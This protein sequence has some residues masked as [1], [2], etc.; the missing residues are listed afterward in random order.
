[1]QKESRQAVDPDNHQSRKGWERISSKVL[2]MYNFLYPTYTGEPVKVII[3]QD[4]GSD[5][6]V[7]LLYAFMSKKFDVKGINV[8]AGNTGVN[9]VLRNTYKALDMAGIGP[10]KAKEI[11]IHL[12]ER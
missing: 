9:N 12:P 4:G 3:D 1:M 11:G 7:A 10:D 5:D 8:V 2:A 6:F